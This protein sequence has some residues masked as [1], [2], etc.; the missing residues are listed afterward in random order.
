MVQI[1]SSL[2]YV[3]KPR[4]YFPNNLFTKEHL[5]QWHQ[6]RRQQETPVK[7]RK[8]SKLNAQFATLL[9]LTELDQCS[10]VPTDPLLEPKKDLPIRKYSHHNHIL[11]HNS[12]H[13]NFSIEL[14]LKV[15]VES[16]T[17]RPSTNGSNHQ[18][19]THQVSYIFRFS[20]ILGLFFSLKSDKI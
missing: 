3:F 9:Q 4:I 19:T 16:G 11:E 20:F 14:L 7:A 8:S 6:K 10:R 5:S 1:N 15:R 18:L 12:Y 13:F 2:T 17:I